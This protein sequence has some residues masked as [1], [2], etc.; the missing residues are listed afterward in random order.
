M[1]GV[2]TQASRLGNYTATQDQ[3]WKLDYVIDQCAQM[4][5]S[6]LLCLDYAADFEASNGWD[7]NPYNVYVVTIQ[8]NHM[9]LIIIM[10]N[11]VNMKMLIC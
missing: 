5:I 1:F 9:I 2:E 8:Y 11:K 4:G 10:T 7:L 6:V 3:H